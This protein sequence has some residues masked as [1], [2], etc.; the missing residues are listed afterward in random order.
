[1][2]VFTAIATAITKAVVAFTWKAFFVAAGKFVLT[3]LVSVGISKVLAKRAMRGANAGGDGGGRIQLPPA[4]D[5]KLPVVY[6]S[7]FMS[8]PIT[9][10]K[11]TTDQ[12]TM[13]Y[14]VSLA[15]VTD[16]TAGS[17][18]TFG[19]IYYDGKLVAFATID[20]AK[21]VSLTTNTTPAQVDTKMAG[22]LYIYLFPNGSSDGVNPLAGSNTSGLTGVDILSDINIPNPW[23]SSDLMTNA[24]YAIVKVIYNVDAGTTGLAGLTVQLQNS[25]NKPGTAILDYML[26]TRYG[27]AIPLSRVDTTSLTALNTYS[28][29]LITYTP[30]GGGSATQARYRVN[31]PL[32]TAATCLENLQA[33]VD[34]CDS[35][36][37]YSELTGKWRV[38][39][40]KSYAPA[41]LSSLFAITDSNLVGGIQINP[42]GLNE[43]YNEVEVAY[44]NRN[45]KDQNDYQVV[46]LSDYQVGVMSPNEAVNRLNFNL[47]LVNNAVQAKYLAVRRLLQSREDLVVQFA[48]DFSGIQIEAGDVIRITFAP[49]GWTDKLFRVSSVA[50][51]KY[52]DG[53][54]GAQIVAFEYN[55]SIYDDNAIQDFV[56]AFNTGLTDPNV[57]TL[58]AAPTV[59]TPTDNQSVKSFTVSA[60]VPTTGTTLYMDFNFGTSSDPTTHRL[61]RTLQIGNGIP[62]AAGAS[63]TLSVTDLPAGTYY[64]SITARNNT[65]GRQGPS[66][67]AYI[68]TGPG[69][70]NYDPN[71]GNGGINGNNLQP[72]SVG[73]NAFSNTITFIDVVG[74]LPGSANQGDVVFLTTNNQLYR[75]T[76]NAWTTAVP[77]V[78]ITGQLIANQIAN[79]ANSAIIGEIVSSQI[80]N[81]AI[82]EEKIAANAVVS[83]AI[84]ANAVTAVKIAA[85]AVE[86]DKIAANAV[87]ANKIAANSIT[88]VAI[89]ANAVTANAILAN[90]V[91][92]NKIDAGAVTA[93]KIAVTQLD[94]ITANMGTL[95]SGNILTDAAPNY[96]TEISS[97]GSFPIWF[98]NGT[99][100]EANALFYVKNDGNVFIKAI[101]DALP[102]SNIP[103]GLSMSVTIDPISAS[104]SGF[105]TTGNVTSG[106]ANVTI[107]NGT[108]PYTYLWTKQLDAL[109]TTTISSNT[110][111]GPSFSATD[112]PDATPYTS[113]WNCQVTDTNSNVATGTAYVRLRWT[114]LS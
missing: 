47:P 16:T 75:Y 111:N 52:T 8:G 22:Y 68:W 4:T 33:L 61:Y 63:T 27:C 91:T 57:F 28:D 10:A 48:T 5:N 17:A 40:N 105:A 42:V 38:I 78:D 35:W 25:I 56:P 88:A 81:A 93:G 96:R 84:F 73:P 83:N 49:Y 53:N 21:V 100:S 82:V 76:G 72:N 41:T 58:P 15:E 87:V 107:T 97:A 106:G 19:D 80:A 43:T 86:S 103:T 12:K 70:T 79:V 32:D 77:A 3:T 46:L 7:A 65:A 66:S 55:D 2:A 18:Y 110:S 102:G 29:A 51:E 89:A 67:T 1:M 30:V 112:V 23:T 37:Q 39:I 62:F 74:T 99:K 113:I 14:V 109:G 90:S 94:A 45:I 50:E 69:V 92:T 34:S 9:D 20:P 31:G 59:T 108:S 60:T 44:P 11:I 95:T 64:W 13:Y 26:N 114:D 101:V 6:G 36:L 54:L 98:G 24:A 71:T 85:G 104:N